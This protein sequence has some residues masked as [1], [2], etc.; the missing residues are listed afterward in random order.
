VNNDRAVGL[1]AEQRSQPASGGQYR[2]RAT[3]S[4]IPEHE[5]ADAGLPH[6]GCGASVKA[7][8]VLHLCLILILI[9][10]VRPRVT[11][12]GEGEKVHLDPTKE[13]PGVQVEDA[14][15]V[16]CYGSCFEI[17]GQ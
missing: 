1:G 7:T 8:P 6:L 13:V 12:P 16:W 3:E 2:P 17:S 15:S 10:T 9:L 5:D 11:E 4:D 14:H